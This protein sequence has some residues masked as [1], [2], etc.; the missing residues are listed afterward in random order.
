MN[1]STS[2]QLSAISSIDGRYRTIVASLAEHFSEYGLIR[3]RITVEC[4][5]LLALSEAGVI[6][7]LSKEEKVILQ[8]LPHISLEE[9]AIV[10]KIE[11]EGYEGIPAKKRLAATS[12]KDIAEWTHF[13]LTSEDINSAAYG[14]ALRGA[15]QSEI[16]PSI[17]GI[18]ASLMTLTEKYAST[19]MLARTHGQPATPTT[20]GKEMRVF[21]SRLA[22]QLG[23]LSK[24][25]IFVKFSGATGSYNAH[26]A[27][28]PDVDWRSFA[29]DLIVRLNV[30]YKISLELNEITTQIE[31]H[32]TYAELFDTMRR[33]NTILVDFSQDIWRY[34][35]DGWLGQKVKE[36][37]I[38]SSAMPHKVN[39]IDFE[40]AEGNLGVANALFEHFSRK[41]PISRLQRDL[42]DSTVLRVFGTAFAHALV[43]Y[44]ALSRGLEKIS[45]NKEAMLEDLRAHPEVISEAIQTVLRREGVEVPYEKLKELT[46]GKKV[47]LDDFAEFIDGLSV[48]DEVKTHLKSLRPEAYIGLAER[49]ARH[50]P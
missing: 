21:E 18:R 48:N 45:V 27:A 20:F 11:K 26:V 38:G 5:Y 33:I 24:Q 25:A 1:E 15:L 9:A 34:I 10:K 46:R 6:R 4:E 44:T 50:S 39:P 2:Y 47:S 19:A 14:M 3:K 12:L 23:Q 32:D 13:A 43:G 41:L 30:G 49:I 22:R 31:P 17:E 28:L 7:A 37:E 42:S 36:G 16:I 35:S 8:Q 40:N 29:K